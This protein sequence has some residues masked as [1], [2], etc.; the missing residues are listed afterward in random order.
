[1]V[2]IHPDHGKVIS[3]FCRKYMAIL[4]HN[5]INYRIFDFDQGDFLEKIKEINFLIYRWGHGHDEVQRAK[6]ILPVI[7]NEAGLKVFP[8]KE[9]CWHFDDK[10]RQYYLLQF[11]GFPVIKSWV[12][13]SR[14]AAMEFANHASYP[15][16]MKLKVGAGSSAVK[17]IRNQKEAKRHIALLF[18]RGVSSRFFFEFPKVLTVNKIK[19]YLRKAGLLKPENYLYW[20]LNKGYAYFQEFLPDNPYDIRITT[21][22]NRAFGFTRNNRPGDFRASGSGSISY[23]LS[24]INMECVKLALKISTQLG[25][26]SM[27]YDFLYDQDKN[28]RIGEI[29]YTYQDKAVYNCTGYWDENLNWHEGH[30]WPQYCQLVDLLGIPDLKQP[31]MK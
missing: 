4:D 27:S 17:M 8:N 6:A 31:E 2:G 30:Y 19:F 22:G 13:W 16:V 11:H 15:I 29:S 12:F 28:I 7:E 14:E 3:D 9:T 10:I 5:D 1:M 21:I 18:D 26:Q 25:F 20:Q 24:R 23:D